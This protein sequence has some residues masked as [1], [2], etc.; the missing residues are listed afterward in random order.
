M[1]VD[2]DDKVVLSAPNGVF[3]HTGDGMVVAATDVSGGWGMVSDKTLKT[4]FENVN[5]QQMFQS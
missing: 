4:G 2:G 5:H 1:H 3:I